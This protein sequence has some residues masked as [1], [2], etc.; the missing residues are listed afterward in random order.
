MPP[1]AP[2]PPGRTRAAPAGSPGATPPGSAAAND[3][4]PQ[5]RTENGERSSPSAGGPMCCPARSSRGAPR[6]AGA[7]PRDSGAIPTPARAA[8][9]AADARS[10][11]APV[12]RRQLHR[13]LLA[14]LL[15]TT[16]QRLATPA[17]RHP[18][19]KSMLVDPA[20]V[21]RTIRRVHD[22]S[23]VFSEAA[24]VVGSLGWGK[25]RT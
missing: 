3:Y 13:Q 12:L 19:A 14:A 10:S 25:G 16:A 23:R 1:A 11:A 24:N 4:G 15:A 21:A 17:G 18:R 7:L 22:S 5:R 8:R 20:P 6:A 9:L 2:A